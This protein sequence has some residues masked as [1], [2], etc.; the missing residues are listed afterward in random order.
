MESL[1]GLGKTNTVRDRRTGVAPDCGGPAPPP[2]RPGTV[3]ALTPLPAYPAREVRR[4]RGNRA[5]LRRRSAAATVST[6]PTIRHSHPAPVAAG[7]WVA[8]KELADGPSDLD[9]WG[10]C[11]GGGGR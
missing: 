9:R 4:R 3:R 10:C 8:D 5:S 6:G 11:R 7:G 1:R 2:P